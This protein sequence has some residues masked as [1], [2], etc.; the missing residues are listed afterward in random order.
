MNGMRDRIIGLGCVLMLVWATA[1]AAWGAQRTFDF[2]AP[3]YGVP[4][5][6]CQENPVPPLF[7]RPGYG[8]QTQGFVVPPAQCGQGGQS[9]PDVTD[10]SDSILTSVLAASGN[11]NRLT[12][13]WEDPT[14]DESWV[15]VVT[16]E[17]GGQDTVFSSPTVHVGAG[18][19]ISMKVSIAAFDDA[20]D[21]NDRQLNPAG[22]LQFALA[23]RETGENLPL[24]EDGGTV[25]PVE[26]VGID[27]AIP[28]GSTNSGMPVPVGG[29]ELVSN[30]PNFSTIEWTFGSDPTE[31][32]VSINGGTPVTKN[33]VDFAGDGVLCGPGDPCE[34][35][36]RGTLDSL[37]LIKPP[38]DDVSKK[39]FVWIDD[40]VIDSGAV[41]DPV[42]VVGP[43]IELDTSVVV[44]NIDAAATEVRLYKNAVLEASQTAPFSGGN[45]HTFTGLS[46][47]AGDVLT[48]TQVIGGIESDPSS[49][50]TVLSAVIFAE[51]F[52]SYGTQADFESVWNTEV[53]S[54]H[55][56]RLETDEAAS[57]PRSAKQPANT[58]VASYVDLVDLG[59]TDINGTDATPLWFTWWFRHGAGTNQRNFIQLRS[60]T[61]G[62]LAGGGLQKIYAVGCYNAA[63]SITTQYQA[64]D[65]LGGGADWFN[66]GVARQNNTWVKMQIKLTSSAVEY[67]VDDQLAQTT[68]R[69]GGN[70]PITTVVLG[71]GLSNNGIPAWYDNLSLSFG[72]TAIEPFGPPST[73]PT[74]TLVTPVNPG[75]TEVTV[76]NLDPSAT[77]VLVYGNGLVIGSELLSSETSKVVPVSTVGVGMEVFARQVIGGVESCGSNLAVALLPIPSITSPVI[78]GD[79]EV[80]VTNI[81]PAATEVRLYKNN[82]LLDS[83]TSPPE[84]FSGGSFT[85]TGLAALVAGDVL[86]AT[87]V[88]GGFESTPSSPVTVVS[89]V[90]QL[91]WQESFDTYDQAAFE[92]AW[93]VLTGSTQPEPVLSSE[94][95]ASCPNS[96]KQPGGGDG[97]TL[98]RR[99][100]SLPSAFNGTDEEPLW[101]TYYFYHGANTN[102]RHYLELRRY[103]G[104]GTSGSLQKIIALGTW[105]ASPTPASEYAARDVFGGGALNWFRLGI[106]HNSNAWNKMQIKISA[107][108]VSFY[109]NDVLGETIPR[110]GSADGFTAIVIGSGLSNPAGI[111]AY[112]DSMSFSTGAFATDPFGPP[113]PSP[114]VVGPVD[115]RD[116][117]VTVTDIDPNATE[118]RLYGDGLLI[119]SEPVSGQSTVVVTTDGFQLI[120]QGTV[121]TAT[122]VID[123]FESCESAGVVAALPSPTVVAPLVDGDTE[124]EVADIDPDA[125]EIRLYVDNVLVATATS[126]PEDFSSGSFTIDG[127]SLVL[128]EVVTAT[129][130]IIGSETAPSAPVTVM[131]GTMTLVFMDDFDGY[132]DQAAFDAVWAQTSGDIDFE[133]ATDQA[134]S[135]PNSAKAPA[136]PTGSDPYRR[137]INFPTPVNGTDIEP[138][139]VTWWFRHEVG[140]NQRNYLQLFSYEGG[141]FGVGGIEKI[142]AMGAYNAVL[143]VTNYQVRDAFGGGPGWFTLPAARQNDT[144]VKMQIKLTGSTT[145]YFINDQLVESTARFGPSIELHSLV[146]GSGLSNDD[147]PAWFDS[148]SVSTGPVAIEA[149]STCCFEPFADFDG[150]GI[151]DHVDF[152]AFQRCL[153]AVGEPILPGCECFDRNDQFA[154][155]TPDGSVTVHDFNDFLDCYTGP[156]IEYDPLVHTACNP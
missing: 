155:G 83:V 22:S 10:G 118:V 43:V 94:Q 109:I 145:E 71:G 147:V 91:L 80:T 53:G 102:Q 7:N 128:G 152:A 47:S 153:T 111:D 139:W 92:A 63:P 108:E 15:R 38:G 70:R 28:A 36:L 129:Q 64:R 115:G 96:M 40:V 123:G 93:P 31:V 120:G 75:D 23:I 88:I 19:K 58:S 124:V 9:P 68:A 37:V 57:C 78:D 72:P 116:F 5:D 141:A 99:A 98:I 117:E 18:S 74:P 33:V 51:D 131:T 35:N 135:C 127:L 85:F 133:L 39:W 34:V 84:D 16:F 6:D 86:T 143:P 95:S 45:Q 48:A 2:N 122:Q 140:G 69:P 42:Q 142:Y 149:P 65:A 100:H 67:Y 32:S 136:A 3:Q 1:P 134:V 125:T 77:E 132:A 41:L 20:I 50:V 52:D 8:F 56:I 76:Q 81:D 11:S 17:A 66:L 27:S 12:F 73:L 105:N 46:L 106:T 61:S 144:W 89:G 82:V 110:V 103:D 126:P 114:T 49:A 113:L 87:Q 25:G 107:S 130:V 24:G 138:L 14:D 148:V 62:T 30:F 104:G 60:Y 90:T 154:S 21:P 54:T 119:G 121:V 112:W 79:T 151:V 137:Y 101:F 156:A 13:T 150:D 146:L 97:A 4:D 55:H 59:L 26:F 29:V 44:Q